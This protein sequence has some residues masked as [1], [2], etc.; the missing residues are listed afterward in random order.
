MH[1]TRISRYMIV[2]YSVQHYPRFSVTAVGLGTHPR[3]RRSTRITIPSVKITPR[4]HYA[5]SNTNNESI[6]SQQQT[7][8]QIAHI[9][10]TKI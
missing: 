1:V 7:A 3:I 9:K 6:L 8:F 2:V 5:L 4:V 10:G